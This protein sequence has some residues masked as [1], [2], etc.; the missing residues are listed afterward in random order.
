M[1][2]EIIILLFTDPV[3]LVLTTMIT[4][5]VSADIFEPRTGILV[6]LEMKN[7]RQCTALIFWI[8]L[9]CHSVIKQYIDADFK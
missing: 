5:R 4:Y 6:M 2:M 9:K 3:T 7:Y 8:A 1:Y